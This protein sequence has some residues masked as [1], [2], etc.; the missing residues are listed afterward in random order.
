MPEFLYKA[1]DSNGKIVRSSINV[2][3]KRSAQLQLA[4]KGLSLL[5]LTLATSQSPTPQNHKSSAP[6]V[7]K[8]KGGDKLAL[9]LLKKVLQLCRGGMPV[10]DVLR[11]L[12][13][14]SLNKDMQAISRE[15]YSAVSQGRTLANAMSDYP[16]IFE[17]SVVHLVEASESSANIV[18]IF[19][20]IVEYLE[21]KSSLKKSVVSAL[22]YP[23]ILCTLAFGVVLFFLFVM[24]PNIKS[25]MESMGGEINTPVKI[26][27][28]L[29]DILIYGLPIAIPL[30]AISIFSFLNWRKT[31]EGLL[32]SDAMLL[33]LPLFGAIFFNSD[34]CRFSNLMSTLFSSGVNTTETFRLAE[35]SIKNSQI[36]Q[37]FKLC[38][39]AINDGA[40]IS[41]SFKKYELLNDDDVDILSIGERT[42][43]LIESFEE[44]RRNHSEI[45]RDAIKIATG[46]LTAVALLGAVVIIFLVALGIVSSVAGLGNQI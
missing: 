45:L 17:P 11:S 2:V 42:G 3:D 41:S 39:T 25:M 13:N 16:K 33:K 24:L 15:L 5:E 43:S 38:K 27:M 21:D 10:G 31:E 30:I 6:Q 19:K 12:A 28:L 29:G 32:K 26:L 35:K 37:K 18:P 4:S 44:I 20:N 8:I 22:I 40:S 14:R 36:R 7:Y 9:A 46:G 23:I 1:I 34:V